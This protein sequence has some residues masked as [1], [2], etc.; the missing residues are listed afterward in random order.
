MN[1][2]QMHKK[3]NAEKNKMSKKKGYRFFIFTLCNDM[4][5]NLTMQVK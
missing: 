2:I 1:G 3:S 5:C 4:R